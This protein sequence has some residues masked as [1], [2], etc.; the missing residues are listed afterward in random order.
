MINLVSFSHPNLHGFSRMKLSRFVP[1][2]VYKEPEPFIPSPLSMRRKRVKS[3]DAKHV[4]QRR[5]YK[6][7]KPKKERI[8]CDQC[9]KRFVPRRSTKRFCC[10][11]C[12][13]QHH[14]IEWK[15]FNRLGLV[16]KWNSLSPDDQARF[17]KLRWM[18]AE[19]EQWH[20]AAFNRLR[21]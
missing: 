8:R 15:K 5:E 11:N 7:N 13:K 19:Y 14:R 1:E 3:R 6:R 12:A 2:D 17:N 4:T 21:T 10:S 18:R 9:F 20:I 16:D